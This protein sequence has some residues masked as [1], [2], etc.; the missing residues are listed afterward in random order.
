[1]STRYDDEPPTAA[2]W[3]DKFVNFAWRTDW[4]QVVLIL[5]LSA[6]GVVAIWSAGEFRQSGFWRSQIVFIAIGWVAYWVVASIDY[7][8][9]LRHARRIYL[10]GVLLLLPVSV[11]AFLK[12]DLG[13]FIRS[14]NGARRWMDFGPFSIQPSEFAKVSALVF[15]AALLARSPIGPFRA[16]WPPSSRSGWPPRRRLS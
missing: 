11:C 2:I 1:M 5:G 4:T 12:V 8:E 13:G 10:A 6:L 16:S 14:I 3:W 7:R 9:F 15:I